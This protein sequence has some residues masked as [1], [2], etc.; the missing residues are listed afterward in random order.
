MLN[1]IR[2]CWR[3]LKEES[4]VVAWESGVFIYGHDFPVMAITTS[5]VRNVNE[6]LS[7][8]ECRKNFKEGVEKFA[9][10]SLQESMAMMFDELKKIVEEKE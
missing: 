6:S 2:A 3:V 7:S 10:V 8:D 9:F 1:R 5:L 4:V